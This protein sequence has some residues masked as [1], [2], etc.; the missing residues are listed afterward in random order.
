MCLNMK[1]MSQLHITLPHPPKFGKSPL[2]TIQRRK[3]S[4]S[5]SFHASKVIFAPLLNCTCVGTIRVK[6]HR[7]WAGGTCVTLL[8]IATL[9]WL[10]GGCF[11]WSALCNGI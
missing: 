3:K 9:S 2:R 6:G 5:T 4:L 8:S 7:L 1:L 10:L 11:Q